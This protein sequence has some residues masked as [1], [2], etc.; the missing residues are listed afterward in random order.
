MITAGVLQFF[1]LVLYAILSPLLLLSDV[2]GSSDISTGIANANTYLV[3]IPF[4]LFLLSVVAVLAFLL[5]FESVYWLYKGIKWLYSKIP[6]V[7]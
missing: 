6:G 4:H 2:S 7:A 1:F 3:S 5:V